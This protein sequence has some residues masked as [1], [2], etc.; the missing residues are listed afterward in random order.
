MRAALGARDEKNRA[1][2]KLGRYVT[3]ELL[4]IRAGGGLVLVISG[5][6]LRGP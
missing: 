3:E 6:L 2:L 5:V 4:D 1:D